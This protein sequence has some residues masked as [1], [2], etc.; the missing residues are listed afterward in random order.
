VS[1]VVYLSLR[2]AGR[3]PDAALRFERGKPVAPFSIGHR[4]AWA[5]GAPG[6]GPRH[7]WVK[8]DGQC[9]VLQRDNIHD[10]VIADGSALSLDPWRVTTLPCVIRLGALRLLADTAFPLV[11][12]PSKERRPHALAGPGGQGDDGASTSVMPIEQ[13]LA[14]RARCQQ[15]RPRRAGS[16]LP[17]STHGVHHNAKLRERRGHDHETRV[18]P[19]ERVPRPRAGST[20][21]SSS[22]PCTA[23]FARTSSFTLPRWRELGRPRAALMAL[24]LV[25]L[26]IV[27]GVLLVGSSPRAREA[28][29]GAGP[30]EAEL[31]RARAAAVRRGQPLTSSESGRR[32]QSE[33]PREPAA[34]G[35]DLAL[36]APE[37]TLSSVGLAADSLPSV[38]SLPTPTPPRPSPRSSGHL[39][40]RAERAADRTLQR[41]A[42]DALAAGDTPRSLLLYQQ[43]ATELPERA[44]YAEAR[45]ILLSGRTAR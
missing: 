28:A 21:T 13:M 37:A 16:H 20:Q 15:H 19:Y 43:L 34:T 39:A 18:M 2:E 27:V 40:P 33:I 7:L 17:Q 41:R 44:V 32:L 38:D 35:P 6:I 11:L 36:P 14:E 1:A 5:L 45:R 31:G 23:I 26:F 8:F 22:S 3:L 4:G 24:V 42:V 25:P 10:E 12:P 29:K 30:L 9:L